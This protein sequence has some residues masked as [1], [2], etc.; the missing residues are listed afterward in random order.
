MTALDRADEV[1]AAWRDFPIAQVP[2]PIVFLDSPV[3]FGEGGFLD[4]NAKLAWL[5]GAIESRVALPDGVM[6][7]LLEGHP[8]SAGSTSLLIS[9]VQQC[10]GT[11]WSDRGPRHLSAYR[12]SISGLAQPCIVLDPQVDCWW[13]PGEL[14]DQVPGLGNATVDE[15][16]LTVHFPAF[17]GFLTEFHRAEF[18]EYPTCVVG[19]AVTS[20]RE[21]PPGTA[22]PAVG[23]RPKVTGRLA[24]PLDGRVLV[25][26]D[27]RPVA[28]LREDPASRRVMGPAT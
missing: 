15:D 10:E 25:D 23:Y 16:D 18:V 1:A 24:M 3:H 5:R 7:M 12:L 27:G 8:H 6:A 14:W 26:T 19:H 4:G 11:F 22:I 20:E 17:G 2:R 9:D 21:V 13:P 28:A